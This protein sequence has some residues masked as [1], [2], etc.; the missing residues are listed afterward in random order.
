MTMKNK[1]Q[2]KEILEKHSDEN[3]TDGMGVEWKERG[4]DGQRNYTEIEESINNRE[5][6]KEARN[7]NYSMQKRGRLQD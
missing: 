3:K 2:S 1:L 5:D 6:E 4:K 7:E